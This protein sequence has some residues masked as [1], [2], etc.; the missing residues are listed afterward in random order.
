MHTPCPEPVT[1]WG[2]QGA[3][4]CLFSE[5]KSSNDSEAGRY[6]VLPLPQLRISSRSKRSRRLRID[7]I[8]CC[9]C[10]RAPGEG[11]P[12]CSND[13]LVLDANHKYQRRRSLVINFRTL[14]SPTSCMQ[15]SSHAIHLSKRTVHPT[16]TTASPHLCVTTDSGCESTQ[17][18]RT[19]RTFIDGSCRR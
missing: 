13:P 19:N 14:L 8:T 4:T 11:R 12:S 5:C 9:R 1:D 7:P 18:C 3:S 6:M 17:T 2:W 15:A 16:M 10:K